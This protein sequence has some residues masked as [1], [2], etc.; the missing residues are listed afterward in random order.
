[1]ADLTCLKMACLSL[2]GFGEYVRI[3]PTLWPT[4]RLERLEP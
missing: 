1:M 3:R 2:R 4:D